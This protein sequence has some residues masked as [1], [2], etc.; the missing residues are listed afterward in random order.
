[1]HSVV[2]AE[3]PSYR[4]DGVVKHVCSRGQPSGETPLHRSAAVQEGRSWP[5]TSLY[6]SNRLH[7]ISLQEQRREQDFIV[8][9]P[10]LALSLVEMEECRP[11]NPVNGIERCRALGIR[12]VFGWML[13]AFPPILVRLVPVAANTR[14][15]KIRGLVRRTVKERAPIPF[16]ADVVLNHPERIISGVTLRTGSGQGQSEKRMGASCRLR[17]IGWKQRTTSV[18]NEMIGQS[19]SRPNEMTSNSVST[20]CLCF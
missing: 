10:S 16:E 20:D 2:I 6:R 1:M 18:L 11:G 4:L 5:R 17:G 15:E 14:R 19:V 9:G 12:N 7:G 8:T 3:E 13:K